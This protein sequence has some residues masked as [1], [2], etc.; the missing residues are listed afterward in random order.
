MGASSSALLPGLLA[1]GDAAGTA[2]PPPD[3]DPG[4]VPSRWW[5]RSCFAGGPGVP[6]AAGSTAGALALA[7]AGA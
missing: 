3:E 2:L 7:L 4:A 5:R 1:T 6:P